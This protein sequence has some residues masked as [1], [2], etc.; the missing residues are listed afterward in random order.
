MLG[1]SARENVSLPHLRALLAGGR[2]GARARSGGSVHE[3]MT[4]VGRARHRA[5]GTRALRVGRQPAEGAVRALAAG[6]PAGAHRGRADPRRGRRLQADD[7]RPARRPRR[8][9]AWACSSCPRRWRRCSGLAHR[10]LVMRNG[11]LVADIDGETATEEIVV[12]LA[13]GSR[14]RGADRMTAHDRAAD[15]RPP[16]GRRKLSPRRLLRRLRDRVGR[17]GAVRVPGADHAETS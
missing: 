2:G 6:G 13:F 3:M 5:G 17:P 16:P 7:L 9:R 8:P 10:I 15:R 11:R 1:R 4:A 12:A 14:A